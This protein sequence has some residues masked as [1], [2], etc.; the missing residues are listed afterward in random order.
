MPIPVG[1]LPP[2]VSDWLNDLEGRVLSLEAPGSPV[3]MFSITSANL[4]A[5][6]AVIY[7]FTFCYVSDLNMTAHSNGAH[8]FRSD[9]GAQI[10]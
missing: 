7:A 1:Q 4:T 10:I 8:W 9:T 6:S 3:M 2:L 5:A